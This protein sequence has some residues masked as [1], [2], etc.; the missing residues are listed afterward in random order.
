MNLDR[1]NGIIMAYECLTIPIIDCLHYIFFCYGK[2]FRC[3]ICN[4]RFN[5]KLDL[6][7]HIKYTHSEIFV[8]VDKSVDFMNTGSVNSMNTGSI[9]LRIKN[10][11]DI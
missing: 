11:K 3:D 2:K 4:K 1:K 9:H 7:D 8:F 10:N 6:V 5:Y